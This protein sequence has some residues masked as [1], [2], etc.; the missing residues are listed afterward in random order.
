MN[1]VS[2]T[3]GGGKTTQMLRWLKDNPGGW[4]LTATE[5]EAR[6][7]RTL[8]PKHLK[9]Q[10]RAAAPGCLLGQRGPAVIDNLDLY[11]TLLLGGEVEA[12]SITAALG[13]GT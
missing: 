4:L 3:R 8:V 7:I 1:I 9:G 12:A 2:K 5:Q 6:H 13:E 11:L 10:V